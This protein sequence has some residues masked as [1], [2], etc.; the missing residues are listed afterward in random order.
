MRYFISLYNVYSARFDMWGAG[1]ETRSMLMSSPSLFCVMGPCF[2]CCG[3]G[4]F[5]F[6][7]P[8]QTAVI[9]RTSLMAEEKGEKAKQEGR[10]ERGEKKGQEKKEGRRGRKEGQEGKEGRKEGRCGR[11]C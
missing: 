4:A 11:C 3:R 2:A 6:A 7:F 1:K 5:V 9:L 8:S 10:K